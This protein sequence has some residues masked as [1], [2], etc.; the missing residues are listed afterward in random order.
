MPNKLS[1]LKATLRRGTLLYG[2]GGAWCNCW[3]H[4]PRMIQTIRNRFNRVIVLP[5]TYESTY[6]IPNTTFFCR[7]RFESQ[8]NMPQA[9]FCHD[10]AFFLDP[11]EAQKGQGVG[12]FYRTDSESARKIQLPPGNVD[13]SDQGVTYSD[14]FPLFETLSCYE[15]IYTD[16]LHVAIASGLLGKE[17]HLFSSSYFKI[18]AIYE[19]SIKGVFDRV[20]F[21]DDYTLASQAHPVAETVLPTP[22]ADVVKSATPHV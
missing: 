8:Q 9:L 11:I 20:Y 14:L 13:I 17:V 7:D 15:V 19:S 21:H 6:D 5:S 1:K 4:G 18:R 22:S 2:G 10:M 3:P 16:R 12:Y